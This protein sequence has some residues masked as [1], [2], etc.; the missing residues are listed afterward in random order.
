[1]NINYDSK[2]IPIQDKIGLSPLDK[3]RIYGK[4]PLDMILHLLLVVFTSVQALLVVSEAT[5]Y[6]RAQERSL[7]NVLISEDEKERQDYKRE[8]Y[9][10]SISQIQEHL[11]SSLT[12]MLNSNDTFFKELVFVNEDEEEIKDLSYIKMDLDYKYN[13]SDIKTEEYIMPVELY[14]NVSENY[15]GPFNK[16]YSDDDIKKFMNIIEKFEL[17]YLFKTYIP[18]Y[19]QDYQECF[20]WNVRQIYDFS[21]GAHI[22]VKLTINNSP[23]EEK[24]NNNNVTKFEIIIITHI[25]VHLMILILAIISIVLFLINFYEVIRIFWMKK[26]I[27]KLM[28]KGIIKG[29][30][31]T[32]KE[33]IVQQ[34]QTISKSVKSWDFFILLGNIFQIISSLMGILEKEN[35]SGSMDIF[36]GF[37]VMLSYICLGKY[38]DYNTKYA[39]IYQTLSRAV[40]NVIPFFIGIM[41]IFIGFTFLGLCL[42]WRSERFT[43]VTDVMKT[44]FALVN[45]DSVYDIVSNITDLSY[46]FGQIYGYSFTILFIVVVMNVFT[47]IIQ[48]AYVS[49]KMKA[50]SHWIYSYFNKNTNHSFENLPDIS[51]MSQTDI[52]RE[53]EKRIILMNQGLNK[54][55]E[56]I[57]SVQKMNISPE[58]KAKLNLILYTKIE[59]IDK[60]ME[61]IRFVWDNKT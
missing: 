5:D 16:S 45:G 55:S 46:F 37:G 21:K 25:W 34:E 15:L 50:Q 27:R 43:N 57:E 39:S 42:F 48:E 22:I 4:F 13:M 10:Y 32:I 11:E 6:F 53:L 51:K 33:K 54:C 18:F 44:L 9:L 19:Y 49:A 41:P 28:K 7:L 59:E 31:S 47:S 26:R 1:M 23:C 2:G 35:M 20:L 56:L 36:V 30:K 60:K 3:F 61:I 52:K 8:T 40:P 38:L 12:K 29:E 17:D 14:Y 58:E 24:I